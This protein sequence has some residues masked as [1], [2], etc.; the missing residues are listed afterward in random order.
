MKH[1]L[2]IAAGIFF[3]IQASAQKTE[4]GLTAGYL[5]IN[6]SS[7]A[8]SSDFGDQ[9]ES[10]NASGFYLGVLADIALSEVFYL[11]PSVVYGNAEESNI[12][13]IPVLAKYYLLE[14]G[15]NLLAGPQVTIITD[16]L[17]G[18][19]KAVGVDLGF[20][21]GYDLNANFFLQAK[22]FFELTNRFDESV[23]GLPEGAQFDYAVNTFFVG[24]GYK[25]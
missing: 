6:A 17:P 10:S 7:S 16:D 5:N 21:A 1:L 19:V 8:T 24:L 12:I 11:Q 23:M 3:T 25:F 13:S 22:Y 18:T 9:K 4:F 20:G 2:F 14:T 15:F